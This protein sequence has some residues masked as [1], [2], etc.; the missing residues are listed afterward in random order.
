MGADDG[1]AA[2]TSAIPLRSQ[3]LSPNGAT[4]GKS[5][6][7]QPTGG[8]SYLWMWGKQ[9]RVGEPASHI[10]R[11]VIHLTER[12]TRVR[13]VLAMIITRKQG[14]KSG[15]EDIHQ[16]GGEARGRCKI[17]DLWIHNA[18]QRAPVAVGHADV[19]STSSSPSSATRQPGRAA[20]RWPAVRKRVRRA[21]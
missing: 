19:P 2:G 11:S 14:E 16:S 8:K 12:S 6:V 4:I 21:S 5:G 15:M 3:H 10:T 13:V 9:G 7:S 17:E 1:R 18:G 20:G